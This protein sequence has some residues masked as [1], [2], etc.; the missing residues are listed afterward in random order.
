MAHAKE[1][2]EQGTFRAFKQVRVAEAEGECGTRY[3]QGKG[4]PDHAGC[5]GLQ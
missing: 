3:W 5:C 4:K 2:S 1:I